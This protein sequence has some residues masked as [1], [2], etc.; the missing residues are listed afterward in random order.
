MTASAPGRTPTRRG[1]RRTSWWSTPGPS[2]SC[3]ARR[4]GFD[5]GLYARRSLARRCSSA[6]PRSCSTLTGEGPH[7]LRRAV[8]DAVPAGALRP[9]LRA[10]VRRRDGELRLRHVERRVHLPRRARRTPSAS[11]AP[12]CC[13]TRWR[14]CGSATSS[15]CAGGTT[16]GSTSRS[17][18][19]PAA[20]RPIGSTEFTDMWAGH[21]GRREAG[22][23]RRG[24]R[25]RPRTPSARSSP[26]SRPPQ[27]SFDDITYPKGAAVLQPARRLRRRGR[28]SSPACGS[29]FRT[30]AWGNTTLARP[31]RRAR[32]RQRTRPRPAGVA[33]WL[34]TSGTDRLTLEADQGV[35]T[36]VATPP[37]GRGAAATPAADRCL[38]RS[39]LT[40]S[41]WWRAS[42]SR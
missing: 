42:R 36:L 38:R 3:A 10:G 19:G 14:T 23:L 39:R 21:A 20:G 26:T 25:G 31:D 32:R 5:L 28:A 6:T 27:A 22:R 4:E 12:W 13:S 24:R 33:G 37:E 29:Y 17:P 40:S 8:R 41:P 30:H 11:C 1:S 15:P 35:L 16:C 2:S 34:E 18:S 9:G 7:L